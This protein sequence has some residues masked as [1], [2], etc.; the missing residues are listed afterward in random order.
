M[1]S[2]F[3]S[4]TVDMVSMATHMIVKLIESERFLRYY[5]HVHK[6][7]SEDIIDL[8]LPSASSSHQEV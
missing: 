5:D 6:V 1:A 8:S 3:T 2:K 7:K 4:K